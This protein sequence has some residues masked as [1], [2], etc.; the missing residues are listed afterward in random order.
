MEKILEKN[1]CSCIRGIRL[2][3]NKPPKFDIEDLIAKLKLLNEGL[4]IDL[5]TKYL[6]V[7][8]DSKN[9]KK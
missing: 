5:N 8:K 3:T 1:I 6:G 9:R 2:G 7:L 4:A